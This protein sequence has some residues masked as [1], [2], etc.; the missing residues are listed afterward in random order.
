MPRRKH[1]RASG[2][3]GRS[4]RSRL[5]LW[6]AFTVFGGLLAASTFA[7]YAAASAHARWT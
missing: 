1:V 6:V 2:L 5:S 3:A 7:F 4:R